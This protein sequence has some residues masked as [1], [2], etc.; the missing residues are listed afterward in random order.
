[1]KIMNKALKIVC[2]IVLVV[3]LLVALSACGQFKSSRPV[4]EFLEKEGKPTYNDIIYSRTDRYGNSFANQYTLYYQSSS[5][6]IVKKERGSYS[7]RVYKDTDTINFVEER[8]N[9]LQPFLYGNSDNPALWYLDDES[10]I[11]KI[12]ITVKNGSDESEEIEL[13]EPLR[14]EMQEAL[15]RQFQEQFDA[16]A[17]RDQN[18]Q[19]SAYVTVYFKDVNASVEASAIVWLTDGTPTLSKDFRFTRLPAA[20]TELL[21]QSQ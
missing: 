7:V 21:G 4:I 8:Y 14:H 9:F 16:D 3:S 5:K 10:C 18:A 6:G 13:T 17:V 20:F 11:R 1:M 2:P 19:R 12:C 15:V